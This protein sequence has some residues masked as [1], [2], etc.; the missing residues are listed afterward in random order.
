MATGIKD[1]S[2]DGFGDRVNQISQCSY[3]DVAENLARHIDGNDP[4]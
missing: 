1:F 3:Q 2:H 4:A